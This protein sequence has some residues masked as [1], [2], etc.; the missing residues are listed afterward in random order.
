MRVP[1]VV[2]G[3][4]RDPR[5]P[6][7]IAER[8]REVP[9]WGRATIGLREYETFVMIRTTQG[10]TLRRLCRPMRAQDRGQLC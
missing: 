3:N 7:Q 8:L 6:Y 4:P 10:E 9:R 5:A 2:Q 1:K